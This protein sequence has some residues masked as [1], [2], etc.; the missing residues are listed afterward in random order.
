[1]NGSLARSSNLSS[2]SRSLDLG[3]PHPRVYENLQVESLKARDGQT[4]PFSD[5]GE[6][7]VMETAVWQKLIGVHGSL[8]SRG[9]IWRLVNTL[10]SGLPVEQ[11]DFPPIKHS[12]FP[13]GGGEVPCLDVNWFLQRK[14]SILLGTELVLS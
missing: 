6:G 1:M 12:P 7:V 5:S 13:L 11:C 4:S 2:G 8:R 3:E 9:F 14:C 10:R